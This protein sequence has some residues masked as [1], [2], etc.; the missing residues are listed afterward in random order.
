[1]AKFVQIERQVDFVGFPHAFHVPG[2]SF[3]S[4]YASPQSLMFWAGVEWC[5][6]H[7]GRD[8][9]ETMYSPRGTWAISSP[10]KPRIFLRNL[11]DAFAFKMRW[12]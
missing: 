5:E 2:H 1:M 4:H 10:Q 6:D 7:L 11:D 8:R 9:Q 12:G 3:G